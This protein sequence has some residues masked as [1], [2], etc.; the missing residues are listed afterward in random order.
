MPER[1]TLRSLNRALLARQGLLSRWELPVPDVVESVGALQAQHWPSVRVALWSRTARVRLDDI[2]EAFERRRLVAGTLLRRTL[3]VV[4]ARQHPVYAVVAREGGDDDSRRT[5][6]GPSADGLESLREEVLVHAGAVPRSRV[7]LVAFIE[8][9]I[10]RHPPVL[11]EPEIARQRQYQWRPLLTSSAF[12]RVAADG[13]W[14]GSRTP[15]DR[16]DAR[17]VHAAHLDG[18]RPPATEEALGALV[19]WHLGAFGPAGADDVA[20]W[21]GWRT[22]PVREAV[23]RLGDE[24]GRFQDEAGRTLYDLPGA[25]RPDPDVPAPP[26]LLPGF[27]SA[28][29]AYAAARRARIVPP[30]SRERI[31]V[32]ANLQVLPTFL[33][34]GMVAGTWSTKAGS[35]E[36]TL[37]LRPFERLGRASRD[38]LVDEAERLLRFSQPAASVHRVE[39]DG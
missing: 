37:S 10:A 4:T 28:L 18:G 20:A 24:L 35:R 14:S 30:S 11:A 12:V 13:D 38:G 34:D 19:R 16:L 1:L 29:L 17:S 33:V 26:R 9:W 36:A 23:D 2:H 5:S 15:D 27:D 3:H 39:F 32:R 6:T 7:E 8:D 22:G 31:Y 21:I 25:P